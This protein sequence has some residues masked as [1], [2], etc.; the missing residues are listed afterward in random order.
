LDSLAFSKMTGH[1]TSRCDS[2]FLA[3]LLIF[4]GPLLLQPALASSCSPVR[5]SVYL[6]CVDRQCDFITATQ[7]L[8]SV[9]TCNRYLIIAPVTPALMQRL[10]Q[11]AAIFPDTDHSGIYR[12]S[13][14]KVWNHDE[15]AFDKTIDDAML[16]AG[17]HSPLPS[18]M[19]SL[20]ASQRESLLIELS[21][22]RR[23]GKVE[24]VS[25]DANPADIRRLRITLAAE[26]RESRWQ[27]WRRFGIEVLPWS[28]IVL[29]GLAL[30]VATHSS[31][32]RHRSR[33]NWRTAAVNMPVLLALWVFACLY[34]LGTSAPNSAFVPLVML[35]LLVEVCLLNVGV[36]VAEALTRSGGD[37]AREPAGADS[38]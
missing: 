18:N 26:V 27:A 1:P 36:A 2:L 13:L 23:Q 28:P 11:L 5:S 9:G 21:S 19:A 32:L 30:S 17:L 34:L 20:S 37:G 6:R 4:V 10:E 31:L 35:A 8:S 14:L 38:R 33:R 15:R 24:L 29:V 7:Q 22:Y 3:A 12:L 25:A 16:R